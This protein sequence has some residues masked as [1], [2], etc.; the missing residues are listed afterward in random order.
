MINAFNDGAFVIACISDVELSRELRNR[1][2]E[3]ENHNANNCNII[4]HVKSNG[5]SSA[6]WFPVA[7]FGIRFARAPQSLLYVDE[8]TRKKK[9]REARAISKLQRLNIVCT[10]LRTVR[11]TGD[12]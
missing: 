5:I 9:K 4:L 1:T 8:R 7:S 3:H 10:T 12:E 2:F 6:E 11:T